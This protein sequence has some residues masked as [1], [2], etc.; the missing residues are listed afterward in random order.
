L[1]VDYIGIF[2]DVAQALDFDEKSVQEVIS[3]LEDVKKELPI[4]IAKCL[5]FFPGVD[6]TVGG[7]EGLIA[8][9]DC[10]PN[11]EKRDAFAA[12]YSV[13]G[14]IWEAL[15]PDP[16]LGPYQADYRW[17]TQ[18]YDSV[19]PPSGNGKLLWHV[20]GAKTIELVHENT[21]LYTI[22]DDLETLILDAE[23]LDSVVGVPEKKGKA[24]EVSLIARLRKHGKDPKFIALGERLEK[25]KER[26]E[27]G[28]IESKEFLKQ[29]LALAR[30]VVEA[31]K[32]VDP[33][34][35]QDKAKAALTELF[36]QVKTEET[37]V[38]VERIVSDIDEI[39]RMVRFPGWQQTTA[40]EREVQKA[41]RKTLLKYHLHRDQDLF[42]R[43]YGYI[44]QYY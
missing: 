13:V 35:E 28:L 27:Q 22:R 3:N 7:Y 34:E 40:G 44:R 42:D 17:L 19:R 16:C 12:E 21:E 5:A 11:N 18:V 37:P 10:L 15:S 26:H 9:Q 41:L 4:Q 43:A 20:L 31:E 2:D 38:V 6:R 8:A 24:L 32:K 30:D 23:L 25:I 39:V 29:L 14:R 1:I 33:V 36:Q